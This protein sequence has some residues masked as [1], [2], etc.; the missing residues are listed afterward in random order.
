MATTKINITIVSAVFACAILLGAV[1]I[2]SAEAKTYV[3]G[4]TFSDDDISVEEA[5]ELGPIDDEDKEKF[6]EC[7]EERDELQGLKEH[8]YT[9]CALRSN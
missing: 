9:H 8:E 4:K 7:I 2:I 3:N 6:E 5:K 1:N